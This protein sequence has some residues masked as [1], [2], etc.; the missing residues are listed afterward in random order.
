MN[1]YSKNKIMINSTDILHYKKKGFDGEKYVKVQKEHILERIEKAGKGRL[2]VEIGGKFL[3]D[4]HAARVLPGFIPDSKKR[5]FSALKDQIEILFCVNADDIISNRQLSNENISY[6]D[7]V[8]TLIKRIEIEIGVKPHVVINNI[9]IQN[10]FDLILDFEKE[11]QRKNYKVWERYK[12]SGYPHST[13]SILSENGFG[14]DDHIPLQ[15]NLILVTGAASNSGKMSTCL[16][17]IYND[18]QLGIESAYAKYETF[19]I[20]NIAL[21]HP[22]N[23]TYEAATLDIGDYN[24]IDPYHLKAYGKESVNYNR[25]VE[26]FEIIMGIAKHIIK[27]ENIMASYK[28]P[29]DMGISCAGLCITDDEVVSIA[30]L[31]EIG[32]RKYR[33]QEVIDRGEWDAQWIEKANELE[34][35]CTHYCEDK[36]YDLNLKLL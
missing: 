1:F 30:S 7:Y 23:L 26:A 13:K 27:P 19:P 24:M 31:E 25:D 32:R 17:Q 4:T 35:K 5:I 18:H 28:S 10:D 36:K 2:Y 21:E 22:I 33:C 14:N 20:W 9:D 15:K 6:H 3:Y 29:T 12:I 8:Q 11:F 16:G 34:Q